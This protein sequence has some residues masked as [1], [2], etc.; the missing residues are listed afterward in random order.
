MQHLMR[1]SQSLIKSKE[2]FR[3]FSFKYLREMFEY[4]ISQGYKISSFEKFS[5]LNLKT[6]ILRHDIDYALAGVKEIAQIEHDLGISA[7][8]LFRVHANEYNIFSPYVLKLILTLK[9]MGHEIGLHFEAE[10]ISDALN[11]ESKEMLKREK[12]FMETVLGFPILTASEHRDISH[13]IYKTP[14]MHEKYNIYDFGFKFYAMDPSY[15]KEM[16][17]ISDSNGTW[18]EGDLYE[19]LSGNNRLQVLIHPDWWSSEHLHLKGP[20][21][22]GLGNGDA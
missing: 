5:N 6:I 1:N 15:C 16:K 8:Y 14:W 19:H 17:Y 9:D 3:P 18:R 7:T 11:I 21:F 22:H 20:Y 10:T 2:K 4:S 13:N 12:S